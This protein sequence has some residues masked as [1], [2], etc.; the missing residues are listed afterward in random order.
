MKIGPSIWP[1]K[2]VAAVARAG[3]PRRPMVFWN[4]KPNPWVIQSRIFQCHS[5]AA[6]AQTTRITGRTR[7]ANTKP[8]P[9]LVWRV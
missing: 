1:M 8:A 5:R 3:G 9:G 6:R 4:R 2:T 7:K